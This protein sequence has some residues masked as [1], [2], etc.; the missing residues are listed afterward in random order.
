MWS[1]WAAEGA[2]L[3]DEAAVA[4]AIFFDDCSPG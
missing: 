4:P 1:G 2:P 3:M